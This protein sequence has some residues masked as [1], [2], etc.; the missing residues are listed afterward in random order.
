MMPISDF[1]YYLDPVKNDAFKSLKKLG[2]IKD[3]ITELSQLNQ[4]DLVL[5]NQVKGEIDLDYKLHWRDI[6]TKHIKY[7]KT[8]YLN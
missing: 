1:C 4:K 3:E 6:I 5:F 2:K 8:Q 7:K